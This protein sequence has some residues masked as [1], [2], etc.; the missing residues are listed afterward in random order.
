MGD[1]ENSYSHFPQHPKSLTTL[2]A[3][4]LIFLITYREILQMFDSC[5]D[6][7]QNYFIS[8]YFQLK[9]YS[10]VT[11]NRG[12]GTQKTNVKHSLLKFQ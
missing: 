7:A 4:E 8:V 11:V 12:F 1:Y 10:L 2:N 5:Y 6:W 9:G 3:T